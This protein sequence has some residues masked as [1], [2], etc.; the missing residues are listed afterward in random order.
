MHLSARLGGLGHLHQF[1]NWPIEIIPADL[2]WVEER[3]DLI[4]CKGERDSFLMKDGALR[5]LLALFEAASGPA[6]A[7][8]SGA[9]R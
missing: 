9:G 2:K 4:L 7:L 3:I 8:L 5:Q 1:V 6:P